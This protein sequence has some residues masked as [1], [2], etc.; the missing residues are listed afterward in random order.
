[1]RAQKILFFF[2]FI[3]LFS[4]CGNTDTSSESDDNL[5]SAQAAK[6]ATAS[7]QDTDMK[8]AEQELKDESKMEDSKI[9]SQAAPSTIN[10]KPP[11]VVK[12][13]Q[14]I[15]TKKEKKR[16]VN[17][18]PIS[19]KEDDEK[20]LGYVKEDNDNK[21]DE[22]KII[23]TSSPKTEIEQEPEIQEEEPAKPVFNHA[24]FDQL[25]RKHVSS[26][27][28]VNY[29]GF[30]TDEAKLDAYLKLLE[31][32]SPKSDW[33]RQKKMA[34]WIN[35]YNAATIKLILKN[36]PVSSI[37][38]LHGGKPWDVKWIKIGDKTYTLNNIENDILRP[39]YKDARIHFAVNCAAKSCPPLLNK[40]WTESNLESNLEKQTRSF[41]KNTSQNT[42]SAKAI[43][44]SKIFEWYAVD[45]GDIITFLNKYSTT[46]INSG[47]KVNY[48]EYD[49]SLN[50]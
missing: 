48:K 20:E 35:A 45:F 4:A 47:A 14:T 2:T 25:L 23:E 6:E 34:F 13:S 44:I 9:E 15:E 21:V 40:A 36:Y 5:N 7:L 49:W 12:A 27:G 32:N 11:K 46:K 10:K 38:K 19:E 29:K 1:M 18:A 41:I 43:T 22:T 30:K 16:E 33:S 39:K 26:A 28:K 37:M 8:Y 42:I 3:L 17:T 24:S 50:N 31:N